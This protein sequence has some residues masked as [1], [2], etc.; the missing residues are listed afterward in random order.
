MTFSALFMATALAL[1]FLG[2]ESSRAAS[3]A[4]LAAKDTG[5]GSEALPF[6]VAL[7]SPA[8]A[9]VLY[10]YARSIKKHGARRT[11]RVSNIGCCFMLFVMF[12]FCKTFMGSDDDGAVTEL[13]KSNSSAVSF[14]VF[15][16]FPFGVM[17][18]LKTSV[19]DN[20]INNDKIVAQVAIIW[21][22]VFREIYVSLLSTQH[23]SFISGVL[24]SS[25]SSNIVSF[26]GIV[27]ISSAVGSVAVEWLVRLGGVRALLFT[28]MIC[29]S[30]SFV[31]SEVAYAINVKSE[32]GSERGDRQ[33]ERTRT[34]SADLMKDV[35]MKGDKKSHRTPEKEREKKEKLLEKKSTSSS[36]WGE[37]W[38]LL[39]KHYTLKLLFLEAV[40]HQGCS[41]MLNLMFH[42]GLRQGLAGDSDR[43][44][45]VGRFFA[46]VN[47]VACGLQLF[48]MPRLLS[49]ETLPV[50]LIAIPVCVGAATALAY[51]HQS[52]LTVMLGFGSM[53][54]LEYSIM[55][56]A[57]EMIYL[58]M[59]HEVRYLGKEL[60]RFFGHKLGKSGTSLLLSA[61]I[62][63]FQP[64][65]Q[66]QT[67]WGA[68][69]VALWGGTLYILSDHLSTRNHESGFLAK[70]KERKQKEE[71]TKKRSSSTSSMTNMTESN[72]H[73]KPKRRGSIDEL[74]N[75]E[76]GYI[77]KG[78]INPYGDEKVDSD[79]SVG[80]EDP[81]N[82]F[83]SQFYY[84]S[85]KGK[86]AEAE[87]AA[88]R[89]SLI[90]SFATVTEETEG[91]TSTDR[92]SL[93]SPPAPSSFRYTETDSPGIDS[94]RKRSDSSLN[95]RY[96]P[97]SVFDSSDF[98]G[99]M[100]ELE[101]SKLSPRSSQGERGDSAK[102]VGFSL[103]NGPA[104]NLADPMIGI[105]RVDSTGSIRS[106]ISSTSSSSAFSRE[107][108]R[109]R[110]LSLDFARD[111][112]RDRV[113]EGGSG[114]VR[115]GS[116]HVSLNY[117]TALSQADA[118]YQDNEQ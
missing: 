43:A 39:S 14:S 49:Q 29:T 62:R 83:D 110:P 53:K 117:L 80:E 5:L 104:A 108:G 10:F 64:G 4:L 37:S 22:Y 48:V 91:A 28:C 87:D 35:G 97:G 116:T 67:M 95:A 17:A 69:L 50:A 52:L 114:L 41:N 32:G 89:Q 90:R 115:I 34:A 66:D 31:F 76:H 112:D 55:S 45:V 72:S 56:S 81:S 61:A 68:S 85:K 15:D 54:V 16:R 94:T 57:M 6:T 101:T 59:G 42:D 11:L 118:D 20:I 96:I 109:D 9:L 60:I 92:S 36:V 77:S 33:R 79:G 102:S 26:A 74:G 1:L 70:V 99:A 82:N 40:L 98:Y 75:S 12:W 103:I 65:L 23:W 71:T 19:E 51:F 63:H 8:G 113:R 88:A 105:P 100:D 18:M 47:L 24:T 30:L 78:L 3:I 38:D 44:T 25:T 107:S 73:R 46:S 21:F 7:G 111:R 93:G 86:E 13:L 2:Y 84:R 27:S 58:P 106:L